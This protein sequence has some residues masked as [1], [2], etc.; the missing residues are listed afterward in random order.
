MRRYV[1]GLVVAV[2]LGL[3]AR[4]CLADSVPIGGIVFDVNIPASG[5]VAGVNSFTL[6]NE[7]GGLTALPNPGVQE[8]LTLS[9]QLV[10][11]L[12]GDTTPLTETFK[13][14]GPGG[15]DILDIPSTD[16]VLSAVLTGT[17]SPT[18]ATRNG[19]SSPVNL[20]AAF[21]VIAPFDGGVQLGTCTD[22]G[23]CSAE[24]DATTAPTSVPEPN[25]FTLLGTGLVAVSLLLKYCGRETARRFPVT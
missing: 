17:L 23:A 21:T 12:F 14:V 7:T 6:F 8:P 22:G 20:L 9:G 3:A 2:V 10:L 19:G 13:D 24:I 15:T 5:L 11:T 25:T 16:E 18:L 4:P 1:L